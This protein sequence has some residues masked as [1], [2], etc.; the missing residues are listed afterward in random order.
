MQDGPNATQE[1]EMM[2]LFSKGLIL[3]AFGSALFV[4]PAQ[5]ASLDDRYES[6][7]LRQAT[8]IDRGV[9]NG[10]INPHEAARLNAQ[11]GRI[12]TRQDR[13]AADGYT[14]RDH[15]RISHRQAD[16]ARNIGRA[17][18]NRR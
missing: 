14:R 8:R 9:S 16:A 2:T 7:S 12:D 6:R 17:G 3:A 15:A 18:Y 10:R 5:A 1:T 13:L 11:Q 4:A